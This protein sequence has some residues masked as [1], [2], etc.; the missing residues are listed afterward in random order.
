MF[1]FT[2][3]IAALASAAAFSAPRQMRMGI[4]QKSSTLYFDWKK[5]NKPGFLK[6]ADA[7]FKDGW[8]PK[9]VDGMSAALPWSDKPVIGDGTLAGDQGFD[10]WNLS[11]VFP[12]TWLRA[13]ELKHGRVCMLA[14]VGLVAPELF[15]HPIGFEGLKFAPEFTE[16]N[17]FKAL[18]TAPGLGLAQILLFCGLVEIFTFG[19]A[20]D[21]TFTYDD[22]LTKI[23][24]EDIDAGAFKFL[25]G[26][27]KNAVAA[28]TASKFDGLTTVD[29]GRAGDIG[30][31]PLGFAD[32][33]V[34]PDYALAELKHGRVAMLGVL[35]M[36]IQQ[37]KTPDFG[38]LEFTGKYFAGE[39]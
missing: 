36:L 32:N 21:G 22:G 25:T 4:D 17:A 29:E 19:K 18:N 26:G 30:F 34:N 7:G 28:D 38:L 31:D 2:L 35:G 23:E 11:S 5:V 14:A 20:Y 12:L 10:P 13:A 16:M 1:R 15:Q 3:A 27:A 8:L 39:V 37:S 6:K 24:K 9:P 33:G